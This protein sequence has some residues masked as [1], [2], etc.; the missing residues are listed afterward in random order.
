MI[1]KR[2]KKLWILSSLD[3]AHLGDLLQRASADAKSHREIPLNGDGDKRKYVES[4]AQII[5]YKKLDPI[6]QIIGDET[7][8]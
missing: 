3:S 6:K 5:S 2:L 7:A 8:I 1:W 4:T